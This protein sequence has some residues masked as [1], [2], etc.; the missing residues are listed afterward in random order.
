ML[1]NQLP[2]SSNLCIEKTC[3]FEPLSHSVNLGFNQDSGYFNG[4]H[5]QI[6][7]VSIILCLQ[8]PKKLLHHAIVAKH[9]A[10]CARTSCGLSQKP[11]N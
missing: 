1:N 4:L 8:V 6:T 11:H 9:C 5:V 2:L 7:N 3:L 10:P